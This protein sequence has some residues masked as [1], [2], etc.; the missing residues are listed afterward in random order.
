LFGALVFGTDWIGTFGLGGKF[1]GKRR[2][3][4]S[5]CFRWECV[6]INGAIVVVGKINAWAKGTITISKAGCLAVLHCIG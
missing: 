1:Y 3:G 2:W 5:G 4:A 6:L